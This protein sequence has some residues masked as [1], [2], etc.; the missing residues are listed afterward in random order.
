MLENWVEFYSLGFID[1]RGE[2]NIKETCVGKKIYEIYYNIHLIICQTRCDKNDHICNCFYIIDTIEKCL[3]EL[4]SE[5]PLFNFRRGIG[6]FETLH[7]YLVPL[8]TAA[9]S[10]SHRVIPKL[11][12][13]LSCLTAPVECLITVGLMRTEDGVHAVT[14]VEE[15]LMGVKSEFADFQTSKCI[16]TFIKSII[17]KVFSGGGA[18]A[19][20]FKLKSFC[21][22]SNC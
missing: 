3:M 12:K 13:F 20:C 5:G 1:S 9:T 17:N 7:K 19:P 14:E 8:L 2:Y 22:N 10:T 11:V 6:Y 18:I 4:M 21:T 15:F 16:V